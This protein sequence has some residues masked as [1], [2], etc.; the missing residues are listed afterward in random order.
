MKRKGECEGKG[1]LYLCYQR[2]V[3]FKKGWPFDL[4]FKLAAYKKIRFISL[5]KVL[6]QNYV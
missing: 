1:R 3:A 4:K 5:D 2:L 6:Q